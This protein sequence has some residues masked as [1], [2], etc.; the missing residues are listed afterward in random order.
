VTT[1][2]PLGAALLTDQPPAQ[3][4]KRLDAKPLIANA[5]GAFRAHSVIGSVGSVARV[6]L[7]CPTR[8]Q[9]VGRSAPILGPAPIGGQEQD[10][11]EQRHR[12]PM[13]PSHGVLFMGW[14]GDDASSAYKIL[15]FNTIF[16]D[17]ISIVCNRVVLMRN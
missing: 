8:F 17:R 14:F 5:A 7:V 2:L 6:P 4:G 3:P 10:A 15:E 16:Q 13:Y 9:L 11:Y 1:G 12:Q